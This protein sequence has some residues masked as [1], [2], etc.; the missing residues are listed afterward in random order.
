MATGHERGN[1]GLAFCKKD[2]YRTCELCVLCLAAM[3]NSHSQIGANLLH[4]L[5]QAENHEK[6]TLEQLYATKPNYSLES[7]GART[8]H[9]Q[10]R[11]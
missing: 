10:I 6:C 11:T 4:A 5:L 1:G 3:K 9:P 8:K 7:L 2:S